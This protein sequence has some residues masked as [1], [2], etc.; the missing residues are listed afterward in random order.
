MIPEGLCASIY[1]QV[2]DIEDEVNGI[3]TY[4]REVQKLDKYEEVKEAA[5]EETKEDATD[6][7]TTEDVVKAAVTGEASDNGSEN[8]SVVK[9]ETDEEVKSDEDAG[10]AE[11][12]NEKN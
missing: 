4:D 9:E 7:V 2:S 6:A 1:T 12:E 10:T 11:A 5:E 3:F 8:K